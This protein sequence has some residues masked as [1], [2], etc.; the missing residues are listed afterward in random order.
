MR[1]S[2][3]PHAEGCECFLTQEFA[4]AVLDIA[5]QLE[6]LLESADRLAQMLDHSGGPQKH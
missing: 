5:G 6:V 4:Y 2:E 3:P 1:G